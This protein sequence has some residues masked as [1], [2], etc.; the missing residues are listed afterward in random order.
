MDMNGKTGEIALLTYSVS[1]DGKVESELMILD[2]ESDAPKKIINLDEGLPI[3]CRYLDNGN[4]SVLFEDCLTLVDPLG[5][6]FSSCALDCTDMY[7]YKLSDTGALVYA[8]RVADNSEKF[9]VHTVLMSEN[10]VKSFSLLIDGRLVGLNISRETAYIITERSAV[11]V[12][13]SSGKDKKVYSSDEK[14]KYF[15]EISDE[16]YACFAT[17]IKKTEIK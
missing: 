9:S 8:K 16:I 1:Y 13:M 2:T 6:T 12:N 4:I 7:S 3:E 11:S 17:S 14:L 5:G 10:S 15:I